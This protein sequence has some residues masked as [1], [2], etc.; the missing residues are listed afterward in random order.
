MCVFTFCS[1]TDSICRMHT[2][3][4]QPHPAAVTPLQTPS[5]QRR[6]PDHRHRLHLFHCAPVRAQNAT[7]MGGQALDSAHLFLLL[8]L[9]L[10]SPFSFWPP[11]C[12]LPLRPLRWLRPG[13]SWPAVFVSWRGGERGP[14]PFPGCVS[15]LLRGQR[16]GHAAVHAPAAPP[17]P[18]P[19][20]TR[21]LKTHLL[22]PAQLHTHVDS[23]ILSW[24]LLLG[25]LLTNTKYKIP[26]RFA[27]FKSHLLHPLDIS[28]Q[29][30]NPKLNASP[31]HLL[32]FFLLSTSVLTFPIP[33]NPTASL[34]FPPASTPL[35]RVASLLHIQLPLCSHPHP[36]LLLVSFLFP[37]H[38]GSL[39]SAKAAHGWYCL[40]NRQGEKKQ[41]AALRSW[42]QE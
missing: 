35:T 4:L 28:P 33:K 7:H 42:T 36:S 14:S 10:F 37:A 3:L 23:S 2:D 18:S 25:V 24:S 15:A 32:A 21:T 17:P 29:S 30:Q 41:M 38:T 6:A 1:H 20:S 8:L 16:E 39:P 31:S 9:V 34:S 40:E 5:L 13:G 11:S 12:L 26:N 19:L 27:S 22:A